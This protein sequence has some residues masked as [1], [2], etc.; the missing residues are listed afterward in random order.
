M[1]YS[2]INNVGEK[3]LLSGDNIFFLLTQKWICKN[4]YIHGDQRRTEPHSW[5]NVLCVTLLDSDMWPW[6]WVTLIRLCQPIW[7]RP[8][9][10]PP[11]HP[12]LCLSFLWLVPDWGVPLVLKHS[13]HAFTVRLMLLISGPSWTLNNPLISLPSGHPGHSYF[14]CMSAVYGYTFPRNL[15]EP[16]SEAIC[17]RAGYDPANSLKLYRKHSLPTQVQGY[18]C[19]CFYL[20]ESVMLMF[21]YF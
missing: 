21:K 8:S 9:M 17:F 16:A 14:C 3:N 20:L 15:A 13:T 4:M 1:V 6:N 11:V 10:D 19:T 18:T 2:G 5:P 12:L 7:P